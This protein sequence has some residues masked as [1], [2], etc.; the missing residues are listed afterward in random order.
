MTLEASC[1]CG[2]CKD[3]VEGDPRYV[4]RCHCKECR[5]ASAG[6]YFYVAYFSA[7]RV[8]SVRHL[9]PAPRSSLQCC[10]ERHPMISHAAPL[11]RSRA[12]QR[13]ALLRQVTTLT[14]DT[15]SRS[16]PEGLI[17]KY[18]RGCKAYVCNDVSIDGKLDRRVRANCRRLLLWKRPEVT[19]TTLGA[20]SVGVHHAACQPSVS[21]GQH[22]IW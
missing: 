22:L 9:P 14:D 17:R 2:N 21:Q 18:C 6:D 5:A 11:D 12:W 1:I 15:E 3:Q 13:R 19:I 10:A 16:S 4:I 7:D 8:S 20:L